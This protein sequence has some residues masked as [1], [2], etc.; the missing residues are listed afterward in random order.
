MSSRLPNVTTMIDTSGRRASI[1]ASTSRV[2]AS[3]VLAAAYA[4]RAARAAGVA[5]ATAAST[6]ATKASA[7]S[8]SETS[9]ASAIGCSSGSRTLTTGLPAASISYTLTGFVAAVSGVWR[10]GMMQQSQSPISAGSSA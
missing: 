10:N 4:R 9:P 5:P 1:A 6:A 2:R 8:A 7:P 3:Q